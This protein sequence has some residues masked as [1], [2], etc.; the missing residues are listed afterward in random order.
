MDA[1]FKDYSCDEIDIGGAKKYLNERGVYLVDAQATNSGGTVS[2]SK[3]AISKGESFDITVTCNSGYEVASLMVNGVEK[4]EDAMKN[5]NG[6]V[7]TIKAADGNQEIRVTF[8]KC[9]GYNL[10]G[11]VKGDDTISKVVDYA[12]EL[13]VTVDYLYPLLAVVPLQL[14]AY[15]IAVCK[16][17][18][19]DQPRNLAK[20][21][22]VE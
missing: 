20:S 8:K 1:I 2:T 16:G 9:D 11:V 10:T 13:P 6:G 22:T 18:N 19:V 7:Y 21:V 3:L 12:I 4:L 17:K 14:L 15:H 5:A